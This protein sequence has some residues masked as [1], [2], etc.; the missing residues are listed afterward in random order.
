MNLLIKVT[1]EVYFLYRRETSFLKM[2]K[3]EMSFLEKTR[4]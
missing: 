3:K 4:K 1:T 2:S